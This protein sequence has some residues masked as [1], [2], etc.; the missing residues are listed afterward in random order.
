MRRVCAGGGER[1]W[2]QWWWSSLV[3]FLRFLWFFAVAHSPLP[4]SVKMRR[5]S[6]Y[7]TECVCLCVCVRLPVRWNSI[8]NT[9]FF[10]FI[11]T[12]C[13]LHVSGR[14]H[15]HFCRG[16]LTVPYSHTFC[17]IVCVHNLFAK[18]TELGSMNSD[19]SR[20]IWIHFFFLSF[21]FTFPESGVVRSAAAVAATVMPA[22]VAVKSLWIF[23]LRFSASDTYFLQYFSTLPPH[24]ANAGNKLQM[25]KV[26]NLFEIWPRSLMNM[27]RPWTEG[28][29]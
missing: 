4:F 10:F 19:S 17:V 6:R 8:W 14:V 16:S 1:R 7:S 12:K 25:K 2:R 11:L 28:S 5:D 3:W 23:Y 22:P 26:Q 29:Q 15:F 20:S 18:S 24:L 9:F 13:V 27:L 21:L